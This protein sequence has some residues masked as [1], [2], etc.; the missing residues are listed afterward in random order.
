MGGAS[1]PAVLI[2]G[3]KV[4][5]ANV[6][7]VELTAGWVKMEPGMVEGGAGA[8]GSA[9]GA[10]CCGGGGRCSPG[11]ELAVV[12]GVVSWTGFDAVTGTVSAGGGG[13]TAVEVGVASG[14]F[15]AWADGFSV[16]SCLGWEG[17]GSSVMDAGDGVDVETEEGSGLA[18]DGGSS[19]V[20]AEID[21][22]GGEGSGSG[23]FS[24]TEGVS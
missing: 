5:T 22:G 13:D 7:L 18:S 4:V 24:A 19:G 21:S 12:A 11:V 23:G 14:T 1:L 16:S 9:A 17:G 8:A 6:V 15:V 10:G 20:V 3:V 2:T